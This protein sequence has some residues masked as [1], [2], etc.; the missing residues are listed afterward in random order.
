MRMDG[1]SEC[2]T[3]GSVLS[4]NRR[5]FSLLGGL[6]APGCFPALQSCSGLQDLASSRRDE[7]DASVICVDI[8]RAILQA[9]SI[10][11]LPQA[12]F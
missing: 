9:M 11:D 4:K 1:F 3:R 5:L 8:A 7:H 2:S 6:A 10:S 12:C